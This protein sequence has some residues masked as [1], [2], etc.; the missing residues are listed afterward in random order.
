MME[1]EWSWHKNSPT[2]VCSND[3]EHDACYSVRGDWG[4][5]SLP[6][7]YLQYLTNAL[8]NYND[9]LYKQGADMARF[10]YE[11]SLI[12][13]VSEINY[14]ENDAISVAPYDNPKMLEVWVKGFKSVIVK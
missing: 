12:D 8:N 4:N 9:L 2:I 10:M 7:A 11:R 5:D 3:F 13:L 14:N 6:P 1:R